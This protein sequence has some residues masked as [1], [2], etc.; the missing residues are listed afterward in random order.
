MFCTSMMDS[1][2]IAAGNYLDHYARALMD[3]VKGIPV[4]RRRVR[5]TT[6]NDCF[7]GTDACGWFMV[8]MEGITTVE[9]A[10][11]LE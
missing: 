1:S 6:Y 8:N 5:L 3:P 4:G 10:Q 7:T 9:A 11:V 2:G